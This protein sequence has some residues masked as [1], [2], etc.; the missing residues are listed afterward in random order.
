MLP[1]ELEMIGANIGNHPD[2]G[3]DDLTEPGRLPLLI[4]PHLNHRRLMAAIRE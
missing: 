3:P 4:H 1:K 2:G